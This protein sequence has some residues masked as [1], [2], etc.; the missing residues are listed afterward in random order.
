MVRNHLEP[1]PDDILL[2]HFFDKIAAIF[3]YKINILRVLNITNQ[4]IYI[5]ER[6][7]IKLNVFPQNTDIKNV[8]DICGNNL[9]K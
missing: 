6:L 2:A 8:N 3:Y 1:F 9:L 4:S 5:K 7:T